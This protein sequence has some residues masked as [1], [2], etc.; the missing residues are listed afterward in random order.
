MRLNKKIA[1]AVSAKL[2]NLQ[3]AG[4]KFLTDAIEADEDF[5]VLIIKRLYDVTLVK[6]FDLSGSK[7]GQLKLN[8]FFPQDLNHIPITI[9][10]NSSALTTLTI[11]GFGTYRNSASIN[12]DYFP[13]IKERY[14][15]AFELLTS[16]ST[17]YFDEELRNVHAFDLP[18]CVQSIVEDILGKRPKKPKTYK[19]LKNLFSIPSIKTDVAKLKELRKNLAPPITELLNDYW[20]GVPLK[21][22]V[23][24]HYTAITAF[25]VNIPLQGIYNIPR[26]MHTWYIPSPDNQNQ[27]Q[28]LG[29]FRD[30]L[31]LYD[32]YSEYMMFISEPTA[33]PTLEHIAPMISIGQMKLGDNS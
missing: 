21:N 25:H 2:S 10:L 16:L 24:R 15:E 28:N 11:L 26:R 8:L 22:E 14:A 13:E 32:A 20:S 30:E 1:A 6:P 9:S 33:F 7:F 12:M 31:A 5:F 29:D 17:R 19:E 23:L 27:T 4:R 18:Y 3:I